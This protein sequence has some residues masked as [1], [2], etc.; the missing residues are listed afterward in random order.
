M[1]AKEGEQRDK[2]VTDVLE[3]DAC[4]VKYE[5]V[6]KQGKDTFEDSELYRR[7]VLRFALYRAFKRIADVPTEENGKKIKK[8]FKE[9]RQANAFSKRR[10]WVIVPI[11]VVIVI[12]VTVMMELKTK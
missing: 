9:A 7:L 4:A 8:D 5:E 3:E 11:V 6:L 10:I 1:D 2:R 12:T